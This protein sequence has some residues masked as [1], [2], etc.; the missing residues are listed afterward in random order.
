[1]VPVPFYCYRSISAALSHVGLVHVDPDR[2]VH[3]HAHDRFRVD[4]AAEPR[5]PVL[6]LDLRTEDGR[7]RAIP[8]LHQH[9][10]ELCIGFV[11]QPPFNLC[12]RVENVG[13]RVTP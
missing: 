6:L 13:V 10:P 2:V 12:D 7:V 11:K 5:V 1:M 3:D 8:H 9:R 4:L